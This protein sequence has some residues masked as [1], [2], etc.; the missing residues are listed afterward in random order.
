MSCRG[1][2]FRIFQHQRNSIYIFPCSEARPVNISI[3][4]GTRCDAY[5]GGILPQL[6]SVLQHLCLQQIAVS[7]GKEA[8]IVDFHTL[9]IRH[10]IE[11]LIIELY[12]LNLWC[13]ASVSKDNAVAAEVVITWT[14]TEV[15]TIEQCILSLA[16]L[17]HN[18]LIHIIPDKATLVQLILIGKIGILVHTTVGIAHGMGIFAAD[19]RLVPMLNQELLDIFHMAVH[20]AFHIAGT[21]VTTIMEQPLIMHQS[22]WVSL[23]EILMKFEYGFAAIGLVATG[24]NQDGRMVLV[25][26][27]HIF[28]PAEHSLLPLWMAVRQSVLINEVTAVPHPAAVGLQIGFIN[29]VDAINI[30]QLIDAAAIWIMAAAYSI[31][32]MLL[33]GNDILLDDLAVAGTA[34]VAVK[35]MAVYALKD[36]TLAVKLHNV[37]IHAEL[38]KAHILWHNLYDVPSLIL[39]SQYQTVEIRSLGTPEGYIFQVVD[40]VGNFLFTQGLQLVNNSLAL[41]VKEPYMELLCSS[42]MP[43][44]IQLQSTVLIIVLRLSL[45]KDILNMDLRLGKEIDIPEQAAETPEVLILQPAAAGIAIYLQHQLVFPVR[46]VWGEVEL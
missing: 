37:A 12:F 21:I 33:H 34:A 40:K 45:H 39:Y 18:S 1:P 27:Q 5:N 28:S 17:C 10:Q 15:T 44:Q 9:S 29:H 38:S 41:L 22:G 8:E 20:L 23:M 35:L 11:I 32:I 4:G 6:L 14:I 46:E 16:V 36:N 43:F 42:T 2:Q 13:Q 7:I 31:D 24:P 25:P 30:A 26:L 3:A 19:K